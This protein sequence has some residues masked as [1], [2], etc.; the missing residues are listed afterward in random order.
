[1]EFCSR[2]GMAY[3]CGGLAGRH[4]EP[5]HRLTAV[6]A[7]PS[8]RATAS[9]VPTQNHVQAAANGLDVCGVVRVA[10]SLLEPQHTFAQ[11]D[12]GGV[13]QVTQF[14]V[15]DHSPSTLTSTD[16]AGS[17]AALP[18]AASPSN[19]RSGWP[20]RAVWGPVNAV[21][22]REDAR[23]AGHERVLPVVRLN[24]EGPPRPQ[25]AV[26]DVPAPRAR[27]LVRSP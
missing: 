19:L 26:D 12:V 21:E 22:T 24:L 25:R 15:N 13:H 23:Y 16:P 14:S 20:Q 5:V 1:M 8:P 11:P 27:L 7:P 4:L 17:A 9:Q 10:A 2:S 6:A 3:R 18:M